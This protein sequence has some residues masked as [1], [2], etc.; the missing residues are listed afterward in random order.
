MNPHKKLTQMGF[1]KTVFHKPGYD[2]I[3]WE[4]AAKTEKVVQVHTPKTLLIT[5]TDMF[6]FSV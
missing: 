1:K 5:V 4:F 2:K 3:T 6:S